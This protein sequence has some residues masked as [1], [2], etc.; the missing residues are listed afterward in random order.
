MLQNM[1][2]GKIWLIKTILKQKI[3]Q[4]ML[5]P[6]STL[7]HPTLEWTASLFSYLYLFQK[8]KLN[9]VKCTLKY[10]ISGCCCFIQQNG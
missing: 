4:R 9:I 5:I 3:I 2:L 10:R 8:Q 6:N 1:I 7:Q